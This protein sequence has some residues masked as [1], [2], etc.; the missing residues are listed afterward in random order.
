MRRF[1]FKLRDY[2]D[3]DT[4]AYVEAYLNTP[5]VEVDE[6]RLFPSILMC[7]G[8]GYSFTS[9]RE[10]EPVA[11]KYLGEGYNVFVLRYSTSGTSD[12]HYPTQLLEVCGAMHV[13]RANYL[14][15]HTK[16]NALVVMGYSAGGHLASMCATMYN[17]Q[18]VLDKIGDDCRPDGAILCYP[19]I[20]SDHN[21]WHSGSMFYLSGYT[22]GDHTHLSTDL[23]VNDDTPPCY[24]WH[25][26]DDA[27][28]PVENSLRFATQ[29]ARHSIPFEMK[30]YP[31]G[32]HGGSL[33]NEIVVAEDNPLAIRVENQGWLNESVAFLKKIGLKI[34][35]DNK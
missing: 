14:E 20:S 34:T 22:E 3:L 23:R 11:L 24:I 27:C 2:I 13:I 28:V 26:S 32:G 16:P 25:C 7:P 5:L 6:N 18:I 9:N 19:V 30:I 15:W 1:D 12:K 17:E 35:Y 21:I 10:A 4:D 29:L 33:H 31:F 8:G